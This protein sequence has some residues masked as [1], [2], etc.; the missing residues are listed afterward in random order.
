VIVD[1]NGKRLTPSHA[2]KGGKRYRYYVSRSLITNPGGTSEP[3]WRLPAVELERLVIKLIGEFLSDQ[4]RN[5]DLCKEANLSPDE[6]VVVLKRANQ[7]AQDLHRGPDG[8]Q[9]P[10][11]SHLI[12]SIVVRA[13][14][15][16][17]ELSRVALLKQ[18]CEGDAAQ[19]RAKKGDRT[20]VL[21]VPCQFRRRGRE[22]RLVIG[23]RSGAGARPDATLIAAL[24][25]AVEAVIG[26]PVSGWV[27]PV[28]RGKYREI[29]AFDAGARL[30]EPRVVDKSKAFPPNS[31]RIGTGNFGGLNRELCIA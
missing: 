13:D 6:S 9:R 12:K 3:S 2:V 1:A 4:N 26:E 21:A 11:L 5:W 16:V 23:D 22:M 31:L 10:L 24:V 30:C 15:I 19:S 20:I 18:L 25:L 7:L 8:G 14:R 28:S 27:F 29:L 17:M